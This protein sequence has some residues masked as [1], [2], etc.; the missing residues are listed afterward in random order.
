MSYAD[1]GAYLFDT[2][3][4]GNANTGHAYGTDLTAA[5]KRELIEYLK[6]L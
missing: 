2:T 4:P 5:Q 3:S 1:E 6:T